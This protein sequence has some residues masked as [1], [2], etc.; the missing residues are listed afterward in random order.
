MDLNRGAKSWPLMTVANPEFPV[1]GRRLVRGAL[2]DLGGA[3][4]ARPPRDPILSFWHTN[5]TKRS[6]LGSPRPPLRG[7][8]PPYGKSWIRHWGG[9][10]SQGSYI[11]K[12][13]YVG[14]ACAGHAP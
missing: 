8:R 3:S 5:F 14:G 2:A 11:S 6:C 12:I 1:G 4:G 7:P 10:N 9:V 13:F